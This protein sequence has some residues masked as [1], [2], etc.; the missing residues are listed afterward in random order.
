MI[1]ALI[2]DYNGVVVND[3][4]LHKEAFRRVLGDAGIALDDEEYYT[5]YLGIPDREVARDALRRA[6]VDSAGLDD[7]ADHILALKALVY[8][9]LTR[10]DL[11]E[12]PGA[13]RFILEAAEAY[14]IAIASGAIR[15][16]VEDGLYRLGVR[17][18]IT[19]VVTIEDVSRGKP[20]PEPFLAAR[21]ALVRA[22][23]L[24]GARHAL[25]AAEPAASFL[26]VEDSPAGLAAARAAWMHAVGVATSRPREDLKPADLVVGDLSELTLARIEAL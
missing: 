17:D 7:E 1:R 13:S 2:L 23:L 12:V 24:D 6:G 8:R 5:R 20:D 22:G 11:P 19:A 10:S 14:P 3:E 18:A 9:N 16:E 4:P 26:V 15:V 25:G 21:S